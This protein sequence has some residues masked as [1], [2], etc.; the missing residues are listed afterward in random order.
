MFGFCPSRLLAQFDVFRVDKQRFCSAKVLEVDCSGST[1]KICFRFP[2]TK[3]GHQEWLD[4]GSPYICPFKSKV[5]VK[6][7]EEP[8]SDVALDPIDEASFSVGGE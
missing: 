7:A 3:G 2:K 4:F 8:V 1:M 5:A 6:T